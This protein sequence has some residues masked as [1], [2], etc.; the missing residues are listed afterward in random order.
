M[1]KSVLKSVN[2]N[3]YY[4]FVNVPHVNGPSWPKDVQKLWNRDHSKEGGVYSSQVTDNWLCYCADGSVFS[5]DPIHTT[6]P[7]TVRSLTYLYLVC[8][9]NG[10]M[11]P[12]IMNEQ[13]I[14]FCSAAG[15]DA[16]IHCERIFAN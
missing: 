1:H 14:V 10:I 4:L 8:E 12:W 7:N 5:G 11:E 13:L 3:K 6:N 2:N 9:E 15:D 16:V